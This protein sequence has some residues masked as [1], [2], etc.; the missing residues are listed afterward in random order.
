MKKL[1]MRRMSSMFLVA[2]MLI[3]FLATPA[4]AT[5]PNA[6]GGTGT[7]FDSITT[8]IVGLIDSLLSPALAIVGAVGALYC[9]VLGVKYAKA[10]EPQDREKAKGHLK[11]AIIG[12]VLIFVLMLALKLAMPILQQW[13]TDNSLPKE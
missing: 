10:E 12:F 13:V 5:E 4:F 8:P 11:S 1:N 7:N 6:T 3:V 9:V 2:M